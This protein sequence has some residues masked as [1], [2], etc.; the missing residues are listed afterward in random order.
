M[1]AVGTDISVTLINCFLQPVDDS[2]PECRGRQAQH[3]HR[4]VRIRGSHTPRQWSRLQLLRHPPKRHQGQGHCQQRNSIG[5]FS[6]L[7]A[8]SEAI[9]KAKQNGLTSLCWSKG[10]GGETGAKVGIDYSFSESFAPPYG[11]RCAYYQ[12][13]QIWVLMELMREV[14]DETR[15]SDYADSQRATLTQRRRSKELVWFQ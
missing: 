9:G 6:I 11:S 8:S 10:K 12:I 15:I 3:L 13:K 7:S 2:L 4:L 14:L 5:A 1:S